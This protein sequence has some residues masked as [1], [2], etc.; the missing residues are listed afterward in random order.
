LN[1]ADDTHRDGDC[2]SEPQRLSWKTCPASGNDERDER[3]RLP[4]DPE[5]KR[6]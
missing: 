3:M 6:G 5:S 4:L 2:S 1:P